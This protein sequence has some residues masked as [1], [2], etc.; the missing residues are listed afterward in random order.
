MALLGWTCLKA[1]QNVTGVEGFNEAAGAF[2][3]E[4]ESVEAWHVTFVKV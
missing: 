2:I 1:H 4:V 3:E